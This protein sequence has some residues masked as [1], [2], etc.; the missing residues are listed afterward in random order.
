M[1]VGSRPTRRGDE[2]L[3]AALTE[4]SREITAAVLARLA[5]SDRTVAA[6]ILSMRFIERFGTAVGAADWTPLLSWVDASCDRYAG[7]LPAPALM[8][9]AVDAVSGA[10]TDIAATGL[11]AA[12]LD[13]VR[14]EVE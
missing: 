4:R 5:G 1:Y 8:T 14:G 7:V 9:A 10:L 3:A 11:E 12:E 2:R 6:E 13:V